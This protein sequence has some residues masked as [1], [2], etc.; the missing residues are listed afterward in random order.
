MDLSEINTPSYIIDRLKIEENCR[1]LKSIEDQTG[2]KIL[3]ALKGFAMFSLFP[4]IRKYLSG[5]SASGLHEAKLGS[6]YFNKEIHVYSPAFSNDE[7]DD[8]MPIADHLIFNSFN[9][10]YRFKD[11]VI[12][13][14]RKIKCGLR[15]NPEYSEVDCEIYNPCSKGS[16]LGI[17]LEHIIKN[18]ISGISGFHFHSLCEQGADVLERTWNNFQNF[19]GNFL[20]KLDWINLGGGHH[21]TQSNYDRHRLIHLLIKITKQYPKL[22]IYLEPGE[23]IALNAGCLVAS[24]L[25]IVNNDINTAILDTSATAH[26]P[27]VLEMPYRPQ[28]VGAG[29]P[30]ELSNTYRLAGMSCLAGDVMGDYSFKNPLKIG[31]KIVFLD[32]AHYTMVKNTTFNGVRLPSISIYHSDQENN[33]NL[34]VVKKFSYLD[35]K[36]RLS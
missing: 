19:F 11:S 21:I 22:K 4:L 33:G 13:N 5:V 28:I 8:L 7:I 26:M 25:D 35:Y 30:G 29:N 3:L 17:T 20:E 1:I 36:N 24:V 6:E 18:D 15:I 27:D 23:A 10:W 16:R 32:M 9:Q 31:D 2:C 14:S 12:S 34:Q